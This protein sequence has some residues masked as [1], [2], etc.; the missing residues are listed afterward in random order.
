MHYFTVV[1]SPALAGAVEL[2]WAYEGYR[3]PHGLER[4]FPTGTVEILLSLT[5]GRLCCRDPLDGHTSGN[6]S[7][8]LVTGVHHRYQLVDTA[9]QY[10]M[11]GVALRPG[12]AWRLFGVAADELTDRHVPME[13]ILGR[14]VREWTDRLWSMRRPVERLRWL[15]AELAR[16]A[17]RSTHDAVAWAVEQCVRYPEAA[18]VATMADECGM[19]ERRLHAL[20]RREV[21]VSPKVFARIRRFQA[22]LGRLQRQRGT[23]LAVLAG[24]AGYADQAHMTRDFRE[25]TGFTPLQ[26]QGLTGSE[27]GVIPERERDQMCPVPVTG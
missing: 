26:Y 7:G 8:M 9:Q 3:P 19:S 1:P 6:W 17:Q 24:E 11:L 21:G 27:L 16:L 23:S 13:E 14:R 20:F 22:A 10:A 18:R 5:D 25:F 4:I 2:L 12:G 15:E